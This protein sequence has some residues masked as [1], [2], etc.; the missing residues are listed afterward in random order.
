MELLT[1]MRHMLMP[2]FVLLQ[3]VLQDSLPLLPLAGPVL[4][5][6]SRSLIHL[7]R[8]RIRSLNLQHLIVVLPRYHHIPL[9]L[10]QPLLLQNLGNAVRSWSQQMMYINS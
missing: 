8:R 6:A 3:F 5:D 10:R 2:C 9:R 4:A 1:R 7:M